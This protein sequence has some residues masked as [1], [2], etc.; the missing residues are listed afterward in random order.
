M[1]RLKRLIDWPVSGQNIR[2]IVEKIKK[3]FAI[4]FT[5]QLF[6]I[7]FIIFYYVSSG[8]YVEYKPEKILNEVGKLGKT[9]TGIEFKNIGNYIKA[10]TKGLYYSLSPIDIPK[11][12]IILDYEDVLRLD[13]QAA[14]KMKYADLQY[15]PNNYNKNNLVKAK[16]V[17]D[18]KSYKIKLRVKGDRRIHFANPEETSYKVDI[19]GTDRL[20]GME[21][22][23][24]Q[25]GITRNYSYEWIFHQLIK[26]EGLLGLIYMPVNISVNGDDLGVF[27]IEESFSKELIERSGRKNGPIYGLDEDKSQS[28]PSLLYEVYSDKYWNNDSDGRSNILMSGY[29]VLN[30]LLSGNEDV[31]SQAVNWE[32]W[33]YFFA[34]TDILGTYHGSVPKSVKYYYN[35]IDGKIEPIAF[36]GHVGAGNFDNFILA[37]FM[38]SRINGSKI[39]C[40]WI[41]PENQWY[42]LFFFDKYGNIREEF[43]LPYLEA[44]KK[45]SSQGYISEFL[46]SNEKHINNLNNIFY[47][48]FAKSDQIG[49]K[50]FV[51]YYFDEGYFER[52]ASLIREK[53]NQVTSIGSTGNHG[54]RIRKM[55]KNDIPIDFKLLCIDGGGKTDIL[56]NQL[57]NDELIVYFEDFDCSVSNI[58]YELDS[59]E[60]V[61]IDSIKSILSN[62][63][64]NEFTFSSESFTHIGSI[65]GLN[66]KKNNTYFINSGDKV[67]IDKNAIIS[68]GDNLVLQK[69]SILSINNNSTLLVKGKLFVAG[70]SANPAS[71]IS[72]DIT[73]MV[74]ID[75]GLLA[76]GT[77]NMSNLRNQPIKGRLLSSGL[78]IVNSFVNL[79][80]LTIDSVN[81]ED[82]VNFVSSISYIKD[83]VIKNSISD[84]IDVDFGE[85]NFSSISCSN[86]GNDCLDLS[87]AQSSGTKMIAKNIGDKALSAGEKTNISI[88]SIDVSGSEIGIASK[89]LSTVKANNASF[90]D[91]RLI[92]AVFEKK[93]EFGPAKLIIKNLITDMQEKEMFIYDLKSLIKINDDIIKGYGYSSGSAVESEMYGNKFGVKT[94]R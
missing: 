36:D 37:D 53:I 77:L 61:E 76:G 38:T 64:D 23:S 42:E 14:N 92:G 6:A 71:I 67:A 75:D 47:S 72:D 46:G 78:N 55:N 43:F 91:V 4:L 9:F 68:S 2:Y 5:I 19:I 50:G 69:G 3:Y 88:D 94:N 41:C 45:Y 83:V 24:I 13:M 66:K 57:I 32:K 31:Y 28:F 39:E 15:T 26:S 60:M 17:L 1:I 51:P 16:M 89:D 20:M 87:G 84:G 48:D 18:E 22:F 82:S 79:D 58:R 12:D 74:I 7:I 86:I 10:S 49:W 11:I 54:I 21:E 56:F 65:D 70:D 30:N 93:E 40:H 59:N 85:F 8:M 52:R 63:I 25:K 81:A 80:K 62:V 27:V 44:L 29:S 34:I 35:P 90:K 73:G 33:A